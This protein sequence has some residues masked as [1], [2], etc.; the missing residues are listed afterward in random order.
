VAAN[1]SRAACFAALAFALAACSHGPSS[2]APSGVLRVAIG[3]E[4]HSLDPISMA[5]GQEM[6][7]D[8]LFSDP[9]TSYDPS[10]NV[11][12][13]ILASRVPTRENG[14]VSADGK[15]IVF[16]LRHGVKW[17]DGAPFTSR[18]VAFTFRQVMNPSNDVVTRLGYDDVRA[19]AT[20]DHY[21]V[22]FSLKRAF[23]PIVTTLFGDA[24]VP[25]G[26]LPEHL[27]HGYS[28]LHATAFESLPVGT[29]PFRVTA[30]HR[31]DRIELAANPTYFLGKPRIARITIV[32]SHNEQ[33]LLTMARAGEIDWAAELSAG[34]YP[35][36]Q[37][38]PGYRVVLVPQNRWFG[39][40]FNLQ[41]KA[42]RD[43]RVRRAVELAIDKPRLARDLTYG[44][45]IPATQDLPPF[46]WASPH[47]P[48]SRY[49]P[50]QA[51]ALM[52]SAGWTVGHPLHLEMAFNQT[53]QTS[54]RTVVVLQ[55][56]LLAIGIAMEPHGY[57]N[58]LF[59]APAAM[60]GIV[61]S[62]RFDLTLGRILNGPEPDNSAEYTCASFPPNG[63]NLSR[64]CNPEMERWQKIAVSSYDRSVRRR[65][66][67]H[68]EAL[69]ERDLPQI[70]LWWPRDVHLVS[71][72]LQNFDPNPFVETW[73]AWRWS[74]AR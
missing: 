25:L 27:L 22:R 49:D 6:V 67:A 1:S 69:L 34:S 54:R 35:D 41:R 47:L 74:L 10:G 52:A 30:W 39:I 8:R 15:T 40:S 72:R 19:V 59:T 43:I 3:T 58:E 63:W 26:M 17:Q 14:D 66:Y 5:N 62:G 11:V 29:G 44:T 16:H 36:A 45:A 7:I 53:E 2:G 23:S 51:R 61:D 48:P 4:P 24:N 42:L 28:S 46:L 57:P 50:T 37:T 18:D 68:I 55:R 33:T 73:D 21:T 56:E 60:G 71:R 9:L 13:P 65:A 70:P 64:Y 20:P 12:M 31:G 32:F 38:I